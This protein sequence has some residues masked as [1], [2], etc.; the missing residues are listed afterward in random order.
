MN[1][2]KNIQDDMYFDDNNTMIGDVADL[3]ESD[4]I[5]GFY[6]Q[7]DHGGQSDSV[8]DYLYDFMNKIKNRDWPIDYYGQWYVVM[9]LLSRCRLIESGVSVRVPWLTEKGELMY[10][11]LRENFFLSLDRINTELDDKILNVD[12]E[13][14]C[15]EDCKKE[16]AAYLDRMIYVREQEPDPKDLRILFQLFCKWE[17]IF[18]AMFQESYDKR[19]RNYGQFLRDRAKV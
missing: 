11:D 9:D 13:D 6:I 10:N 12:D 14:L 7:I 16:I 5:L 4:L 18:E 19:I 17:V 3:D 1:C 8:C 2:K 15:K